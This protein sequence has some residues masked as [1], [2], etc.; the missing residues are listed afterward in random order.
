MSSAII[1]DPFASPLNTTQYLVTVSNQFA[2]TDTAT[3]LVTVDEKPTANAGP[4]KT[5]IQGHPATLSGSATGLAISYSWSPAIYIDN[6]Q[7]LQP[8]ANPPG[9]ID[10]VLTVVSTNGCGTAI[11]T[12]HVFWYKDIFI[13]TAFSP[14]GDG[15]ND[16]WKIPALSAFPTFELLVFNRYGEVVFQNKNTNLPWD[17]TYKGMPAP[18]GSYVYQISLNQPPGC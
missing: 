12:M 3:V 11:D 5:I 6:A 1:P 14:N 13:P 15:I 17:G 9:D 4:D 7:T 10:Y 2:C 18:I 16:T 8:V